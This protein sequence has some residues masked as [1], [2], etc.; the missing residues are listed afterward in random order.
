[1]EWSICAHYRNI[2]PIEGNSDSAQN[3]QSDTT[4]LAELVK[5]IAR[6]DANQRDPD[7]A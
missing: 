3:E 2:V 7:Q 4:A 6:D 5:K 1:M